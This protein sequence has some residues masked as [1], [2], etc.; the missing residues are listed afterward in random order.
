MFEV[1]GGERK[2]L[3]FYRQSWEVIDD[4]LKEEVRKG[5]GISR[6][7]REMEVNFKIIGVINLEQLFLG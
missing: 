4:V 2:G 6:L 7:F 1:G 3:N 5:G